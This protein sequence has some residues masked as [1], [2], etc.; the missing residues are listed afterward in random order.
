[1]RGTVEEWSY[2]T[3]LQKGISHFFQTEAS[4]HDASDGIMPF[5]IP[6]FSEFHPPHP[7]LR[8]DKICFGA[9]LKDIACNRIHHIECFVN[10]EV[11]FLYPILI[12]F[13]LLLG[14]SDGSSD[15]ALLLSSRDLSSRFSCRVI[16]FSVDA[17]V[18]LIRPF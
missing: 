1:M 7:H 15:A 8:C 11:V 14:A 13:H 17:L 16:V 3:S 4:M 6:S 5:E 10:A 9:L 18:I 2:I 12:H